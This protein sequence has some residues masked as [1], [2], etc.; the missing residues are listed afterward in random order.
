MCK[1]S[2]IHDLFLAIRMYPFPWNIHVQYNNWYNYSL[3]TINF[4][5]EYM[6]E[7]I[8]PSGIVGLPLKREQ[9]LNGTGFL[10]INLL[11]VQLV[12]STMKPPWSSCVREMNRGHPLA[13][14]M[15][16]LSPWKLVLSGSG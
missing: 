7:R 4:I 9:F 6:P 10:S 14:F 8:L 11:L 5:L 1:R 16:V 12:L 13:T 15:S 3:N 2:S